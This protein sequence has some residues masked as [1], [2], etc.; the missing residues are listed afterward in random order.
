MVD[1][2]KRAAPN[3]VLLRVDL[4]GVSY[5]LDADGLRDAAV[6]T[7]R[8]VEETLAGRTLR[9]E[10]RE[11]KTL[12]ADSSA[13]LES[14]V[15]HLVAM[16]GCVRCGKRSVN[17]LQQYG[18]RD[19]LRDEFEA[20]RRAPLLEDAIDGKRRNRDRYPKP[21]RVVVQSSMDAHDKTGDRKR[22]KDDERNAWSRR[23]GDGSPDVA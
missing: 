5:I 8:V 17:G 1:A 11:L 7:R 21:G 14:G 15:H 23:C 3:Q 18:G 22:H 4:S 6:A 16:I 12:H 10:T 20:K 9:G 13:E 19:N 2:R